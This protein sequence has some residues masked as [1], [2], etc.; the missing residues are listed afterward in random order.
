MK[1]E[2]LDLEKEEFTL[3]TECH[4]DCIIA[5]NSIHRMND[6]DIVF[7]NIKKL[8]F[9]DGIL[10]MLELTI[11]TYLK[12]ITA[13]ILEDGK[14]CKRD[15]VIL[16]NEQ[17][18][19]VLVRNEF[20]K[21]CVYPEN[22]T[23]G[24]RSIFISMLQ[25]SV[26]ILNN[27][28]ISTSIK[29]KLPEYMIPKVYYALEK[30][31]L[32]KN[33][34]ID[35]K[36]LRKL[37]S[38]EVDVSLKEQAI[39]ETEKE[40]KNIWIEV[41]KLKEIGILDNYFLLG[42][43]SL[44]ATRMLTKVRDKFKVAFS[45]KDI[46]S[47]KTIRE[48]AK[49]IDEL[50]KINKKIEIQE[51]PV[52]IPDKRN[53]NKPFTLTEVQQAYW[54]GRSGVYD[55][56]QVS[57]HCYFELDGNNIDIVKL[58]SAWNDMIK[59]HGM[60]R[61]VILESGK[62]QILKTVPEYQIITK[63]LEG[64]ENSAV[65]NQLEKIR[66][67]MSHQVI[68][69]ETW[70]L[71]DIKATVIKN[72]TTRIHVSFDNLI[73]DGWSMFH[74][75]NEWAKRYRGEVD[76]IPNL[77]ISFRDYV[78]GLEKIKDL[79]AYQKDK[80]Y[81]LNR[82][83]NFALAPEL[84]LD[85]NE[86]EITK[87]RFTRRE[88]YLNKNEWESLKNSA[89]KHGITP[90][91]LLITSYTEVLRR[92]SNNKEF[93][94]NLTQFDRKPL[95]SQ[96]N[97]LVG[98][99]TTLTLLE[100]K[101][102]KE[103]NFIKRAEIVQTQLMEDL[104][105]T[106]YSAVEFERELK[107]KNGG[108]RGS[109]MPIVFTSGLGI[110][111][112]N[113]GKWIGKLVYNV[114]QT[115]QVWLDHQVVE[116]DGGLGLFWDSVDEL[117]YPG[118][119]DEMFKAY[120]ELLKD[121]AYN[122]ER[123]IQETI[124]LVNVSISEVR[125]NANETVKSFPDKSLDQLFLE[126]ERKFPEKIAIVN[127]EYRLTYKEVKEKSLYI[128]KQLQQACI[129]K[130]EHMAILMEK[131]W[132]QI[133]SVF[134]VLFSGATYL[135]LDIKNP[136]E[137]LEKILHDSKIKSILVNREFLEEN[138]WLRRWNCII[139][140]GLGREEDISIIADK[141]TDSLAYT[142]Y[143]SGSTGMPKGVMISH[144]SA[145]NTIL[146]INSRFDIDEND[147]ALTVSNLHFD[148][149]VYDIFGILG[150]GGKIVI[151]DSDKAKDPEHWIELMNK[152]GITIWNSVPTF[153]E[154]LVEYESHQNR[155]FRKKLRLVMMSGD[156]IAT[157]LPNRIR[158]I[159]GDLRIISMGGATEAS[160]WSNVFE[161][162][163]NIP[164]NWNSI[165]Y[166]KPLSNQKY[167][168]LDSTLQ[169][170]P[171]WVIGELY[172]SGQGLAKGYLNNHKKTEEKFI[173]HSE[174]GE[175]LYSTGDIGR[176]WRDGNIEFLGRS[177][178]QIKINGYR[179][180]LGEIESALIKLQGI[181]RAVVIPISSDN[182]V[183]II[184]FVESANDIKDSI[185]KEQLSLLIPEYEIPKYIIKLSSFP[186]SNNGK[187]DRKELN[188]IWEEQKIDQPEE[189]ILLPRTEI[190]ENILILFERILGINTGIQRGF[191]ES[192]GDS[193]KGIRLVNLL[194]E[195]LNCNISLKDLY[196]YSTVEKIAGF[197]EEQ[198]EDFEEGT[199]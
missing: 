169:N 103:D 17:W 121:L 35:R 95:H 33:G 171:D 149:S 105:H 86:N 167:Y 186:L 93:T 139:V 166:G 178:N 190:E 102:S 116:R 39:T 98:D 55:L 114:S 104:N 73:F 124:S 90:S 38:K 122:E 147:V 110:D 46:M 23:L 164:E 192:G 82:I 181:N 49:Q 188:K 15:S 143:T 5:L 154:M 85:K 16:D 175:R 123:F 19:S 113:E 145:M 136:K 197:I 76:E 68:T 133:V 158:N 58:Q 131:S 174:I 67:E 72:N 31:P 47:L 112:W 70:P 173:Y 144:K 32:S 12:D 20:D 9:S 77:Q 129:E 118:M 138:K 141:N 41:F 34:K 163:K 8:L 196:K 137:R 134:G 66:L 78:L 57:T 28:Y 159:F 199:L 83:D 11:K 150:S 135:P 120:T 198:Q 111:Q 14:E 51:F 59:Q 44:I 37:R 87:Q 10:I 50:L 94:L 146:D 53:E 80:E 79:G 189:M 61:V 71:F 96:V 162:D 155:L 182:K 119:L 30:L 40:L 56:G 22:G 108:T 92:W 6:L 101:N 52:I 42:G 142:I 84:P 187:I 18:K 180:E 43:D 26:Y 185:I 156:W 179:V 148:L 25:E 168:I 177:D 99:F 36:S 176:Y 107:R 127:K 88:A 21:V 140:D 62:Q 170:C 128:C 125:K 7:K 191:F 2:L 91:V 75:L 48:Q 193:L 109:I 183:S 165:P 54:I 81:W 24:G 172:I 1:F 29:E 4:Y 157:S 74:L 45:I 130:E 117:F 100:V 69:T 132:E 64:L 60:M 65:E 89:K 160:I 126:A 97:D 161:V 153:V 194:K 13:T 27:E 151:P 195:E 115:P 63:N 106:F 152:E 184:A 3:E